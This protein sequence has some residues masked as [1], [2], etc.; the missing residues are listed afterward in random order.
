[1]TRRQ[2][3][4]GGFSLIELMVAT[5]VLAILVVIIFNL[6]NAASSSLK[7]SSAKIEA[8]SSARSAFDVITRTLSA[9]TLNTYYDYYDAARQRRTVASTNFAPAIYGRY[10][11]LE[12]VSGKSL[13]TAPRAQVTHAMFFQTP[14]DY[15]EVP[16]YQQLGGLLN[17]V[18]F[19][20]E[21]KDDASERP[22]VIGAAHTKRHR[23]RLMQLL[24]PTESFSVYNFSGS[25]SH[26]W[27]KTPISAANAPVRLLAENIIALAI[28]PRLPEDT[29]VSS[30]TTTYEYDSNIANA[31]PTVSWAAGS[32]QPITMNQLPPVVRVVLV[33]L[34]ERSMIRAQ[35]GSNPPDLGFSYADVLQ[36]PAKLEADLKKIGDAL[37]AKRL[38]YKIFQTDVAIR[39]AKWSP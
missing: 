16:S 27:F 35:N 39:G 24:Q 29:T 23:Y 9:A 18:G 10:S 37:A 30:L 25:A 11:E 12:F 21:F 28:V 22:S 32:P 19:F 38:N 15:T 5:A 1:M 33:A 34:D 26:N 6:T 13:V 2:K 8:F 3:G 14:R 7:Y 31:N 17:T 4:P 20:I 36:D